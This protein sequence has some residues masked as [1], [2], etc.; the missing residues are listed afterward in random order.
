MSGQER[1]ILRPITRDDTELIVRWRNNPRVRDRF[2][3]REPFTKETHERWIT[4]HIEGKRDVVQWIVCERQAAG[5]ERPIG[6]V[7]FR[8]IDREQSTAEYGVLIGE[9]DAVGH[10]YGNEIV[11]LACVRARDELGLKHV[12]LRVFCDNVVAIRS[13]EH[14]GFAVTRKLAD[15]RCSDGE[16]SDMF[17][18]E[19]EL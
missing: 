7:Y 8:D 9:D 2:V 11:E 13:Y 16:T 5:E 4:E 10:G 1:L 15:V 6:S 17:M 18:M 14:A 3:Y 19:R 12:I